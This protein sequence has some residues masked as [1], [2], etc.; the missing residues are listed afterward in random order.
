MDKYFPAAKLADIKVGK[1][2]CA[3]VDGHKVVL[4]KIGDDYFATTGI[5]T[6]S[7]GV[8]CQGTL[9]GNV[10]TCP[11][12]GSKF[13]VQSGKVLQGPANDPIKIYET[14]IAGDTLEVNL[15]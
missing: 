9:D 8:L 10:V 15:A 3:E 13:E 4:Y 5:C 11:L 6:H 7:G 2:N 1:P 12:H 14:R